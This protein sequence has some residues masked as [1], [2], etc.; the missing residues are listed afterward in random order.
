MDSCETYMVS[1]CGD[2]WRFRLSVVRRLSYLGSVVS[3]RS[4]LL[5]SDA[6]VSYYG[7]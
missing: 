1:F 5:D 2:K 6:M 7:E 3:E 4:H